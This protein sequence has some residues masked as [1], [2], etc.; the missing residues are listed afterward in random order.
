[1]TVSSELSY[2]ILALDSYNRGYDEGVPDLGGLG[3]MVGS[4][5]FIAQSRIEDEA[6]EVD[7]SF[8]A[9]AYQEASGNIVISDRGADDPT[10]GV[11]LNAWMGG[12]GFQT[13][14]AELAAQFRRVG[15]NPPSR[16]EWWVGTHPTP[17]APW[18]GSL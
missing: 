17:S 7:A 2:A 4:Y 5:E 18:D 15:A 1:M 8:Y 13:A 6:P 11:D 3:S 16:C 14:Q 10:F 9:I 12:A